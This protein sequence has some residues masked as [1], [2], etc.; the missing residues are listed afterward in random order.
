MSTFIPIYFIQVT[1]QFD[2][3]LQP[4]TRLRKNDKKSP[5]LLVNFKNLRLARGT[6]V[7]Y[8]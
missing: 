6:D 2:S 1:D 7:V 4:E 5:H 3:F 8:H